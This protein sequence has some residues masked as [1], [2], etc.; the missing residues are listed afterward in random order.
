[1][2]VEIHLYPDAYHDF[3]FPNLPVS[4][5]P[6]FAKRNGATPITGTN[7]AARADAIERVTAY[8]EHYLKH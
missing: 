6:E 3:D 1:M 4:E 7:P 5:R 8:L 2:P